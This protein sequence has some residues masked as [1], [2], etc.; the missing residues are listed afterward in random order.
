MSK[1]AL[2]D[3]FSG[4]DA[5]IGGYCGAETALSF[6]DT[7]AEFEALRSK[8]AVYDLGWR[9][10]IIASGKDRVRWL[11]GMITNNIRDLQQGWGN[12]SFALT[13][14]GHIQGDLYTYNRGEYLM[15]S[16]E[17]FQTQGILERLRKYIIM[18]K[19]E[20][21]DVSD[22]L[23]SIGIQGPKSRDILAASLNPP[24]VEPMQIADFTW[25]GIG[26]SITRMAS[27]DSLTYEIWTS[28]ENAGAVWDAVTSAGA[29][30][31]GMEALELFRV[32]AGIPRFGQDIRDRD[33]PQET[34]QE[35]ALNFNKGC[36]IGQEIVERIR[37]RGAVHRTLAGFLVEG[38]RPEPGTKVR[39]G[40]KEVGEVTSALPVPSREGERVLALGI[41]R[42][43]AAKPGTQV[44]LGE[45]AATVSPLPFPE[46]KSI[47][48]N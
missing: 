32:A 1:M 29:R 10:K 18:D 5:R 17:R 39:F 47:E 16:A 43:E 14:Q 30:P 27:P 40:D 21:E 9:S 15:L 3:K 4:L 25:N 26:L 38:G 20:L 19:V 44:H 28:S 31:A 46:A 48:Q 34:G 22:R 33:L 2:T 13:P 6:G 35:Q 36:Y 11:N 12:Y 41:I 24:E 45:L 37:A 7:R 23:T 8:C 42:R